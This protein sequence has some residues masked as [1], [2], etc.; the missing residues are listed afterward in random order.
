MVS[1]LQGQHRKIAE[2]ERKV[3]E[4]VGMLEQSERRCFALEERN[5]E[6]QDEL[7]NNTRTYLR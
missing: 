1:A 7:D 3:G 4:V 5:K 6:L 2:L